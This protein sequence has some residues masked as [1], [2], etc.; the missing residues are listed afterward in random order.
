MPTVQLSWARG[1]TLDGAANRITEATGG[2]AP[3]GMVDINIAN[4]ATKEDVVKGL[5]IAIAKVI[6][7][8]NLP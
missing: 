5:Q 8:P 7:S 3:T 2:S 6:E 1:A 4:G